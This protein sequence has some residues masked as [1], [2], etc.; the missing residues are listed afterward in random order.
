MIL[1]LIFK[2]IEKTFKTPKSF[3]YHLFD[4][5]FEKKILKKTIKKKYINPNIINDFYYEGYSK[6]NNF[7]KF[8]TNLIKEISKDNPK[9]IN[10]TKK[11]LITKEIYNLVK[12]FCENE[13]DEI[14]KD[15]KNFFGSE[16]Y[17][18]GI[19]IA[20]NFYHDGKED[21]YANKYHLDNNRFTLFKIFILLS[22]VDLNSGPTNIINIKNT[23]LFK[24]VTNY[25]SRKLYNELQHENIIFKNTGNFGDMLLCS[26]SRCF[27]KAGVVNKNKSRLMLT[28]T[29][30]S[31]PSKNDKTNYCK[32]IENEGNINIYNK[33]SKSK[34]I[35]DNFNLYLSYYKNSKI[36]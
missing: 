30:V 23:K 11:Y 6:I 25:K 18:A 28:L 19:K 3:Q 24:K 20:K 26:T 4:F 16:I 12:N 14:L 17:L 7:K 5:F 31:Y 29:F 8:S 9:I 27:H 22:D 1:K 10:F 34:N 32:L 36:I 2:I 35:I 15:L 33:L 21:V 13:I